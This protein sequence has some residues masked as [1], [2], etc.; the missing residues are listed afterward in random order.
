MDSSTHKYTVIFS[1]VW[2]QEQKELSSTERHET[3]HEVQNVICA[4]LITGVRYNNEL[5]WDTIRI[6][7]HETMILCLEQ[8]AAVCLSNWAF[9]GQICLL[10]W[11][12]WRPKETNPSFFWLRDPRPHPQN[13]NSCIFFS[14]KYLYSRKILRGKK[15]KIKEAELSFRCSFDVLFS[16]HI[17]SSRILFNIILPFCLIEHL[18]H[19]SLLLCSIQNM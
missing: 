4:H 3:C 2:L 13:C 7:D 6:F 1:C 9:G 19:L 17:D 15:A 10:K 12:I 14:H 16:R 5:A 18:E 8:P 11:K